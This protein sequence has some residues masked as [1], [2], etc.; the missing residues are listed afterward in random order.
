MCSFLRVDMPSVLLDSRA[1][2]SQLSVLRCDLTIS[3][4]YMRLFWLHSAR[5]RTHHGE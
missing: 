5:H 2:V 4:A 3:R 1:S